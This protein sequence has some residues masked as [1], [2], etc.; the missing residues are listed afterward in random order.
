MTE[1]Q[2]RAFPPFKVLPVYDESD[3]R[4][5][6]ITSGQGRSGKLKECTTIA[7][8]ENCLKDPNLV[9]LGGLR[10]GP[11]GQKVIVAYFGEIE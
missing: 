8:V 2:L 11:N 3:V 4:A 5:N 6:D 1:D 7:E 10:V 9:P